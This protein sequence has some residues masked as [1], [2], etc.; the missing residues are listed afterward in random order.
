[1]NLE[2]E[3]EGDGEPICTRSSDRTVP[4]FTSSGNGETH[5]TARTSPRSRAA[6]LV[7][8]RGQDTSSTAK[9]ARVDWD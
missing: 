5:S 8:C 2:D 4:A 9:R 6:N 7:G 1:M 3:G